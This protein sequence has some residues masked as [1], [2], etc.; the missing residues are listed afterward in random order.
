[1]S[2]QEDDVTSF[3]VP[4]PPCFCANCNKG[5]ETKHRLLKCARCKLARYCSRKCQREHFTLHKHCCKAISILRKRLVEDGDVSARGLMADAIVSTTYRS[6]ATMEQ[7]FSGYAAALSLYLEDD[8]A[9]EK[10]ATT[11]PLLCAV[12]G[13]DDAAMSFMQH[14]SMVVSSRDNY[15]SLDPKH[16][17]VTHLVTVLFIR[18][19]IVADLERDQT[20]Y[21]VF[22]TT[23]LGRKVKRIL[24]IQ[25]CLVGQSGWMQKQNEQ[26]EEVREL[27]DSELLETIQNCI[28][29]SPEEAPVLFDSGTPMEFWLLLQ[30]CF[31]LTPGV[32]QLLDQDEIVMDD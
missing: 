17:N 18:M 11:I 6:S 21:K 23:T 25:E 32:F 29:L 3:G 8:D 5:E 24:R 30:D 2:E 19:R 12:F 28:P 7:G 1:M 4:Q 13:L 22:K 10:H 9:Q 14:G 26:I 31:F 16:S 15:I 27:I 20:N